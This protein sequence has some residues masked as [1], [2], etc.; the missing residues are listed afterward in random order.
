MPSKEG[1][2]GRINLEPLQTNWRAG[3]SAVLREALLYSAAVSAKPRRIAGVAVAAPRH[4]CPPPKTLPS[5]SED[6]AFLLSSVSCTI[7][8]S[9]ASPTNGTH[10][11]GKGVPAV[12]PY[13]VAAKPHRDIKAPPSQRRTPIRFSLSLLSRSSKEGFDSTHFVST[14]GHCLSGFQRPIVDLFPDLTCPFSHSTVASV[15]FLDRPWLTYLWT[16]FLRPMLGF[17]KTCS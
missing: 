16:S 13:E 3:I 8:W 6:S 1:R 15:L 11:T 12:V 17:L 9:L 4:G 14:I 5:G 7:S 2:V 10:Q